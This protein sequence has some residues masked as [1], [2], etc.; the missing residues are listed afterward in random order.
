MNT[1]YNNQ[2]KGTSLINTQREK[3]ENKRSEASTHRSD[4]FEFLAKDLAQE[5][6]RSGKTYQENFSDL[7]QQLLKSGLTAKDVIGQ[8]SGKCDFF[9]QFELSNQSKLL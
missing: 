9:D 7:N 3:I 6:H 1:E 5:D 8:I 2:V 4:Y